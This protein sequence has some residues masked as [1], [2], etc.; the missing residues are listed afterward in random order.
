VP[1]SA[2]RSGAGGALRGRASSCVWAS[3]SGRGVGRITSAPCASARASHASVFATC[4]VARA[5]SRACRGWTITPGRPAV[6]HAVVAPRSR[7]PGASRTIRVGG[8]ACT[9]ST[10]VTTPPASW[11]TAHRAPAGRT[12]LSPWACATSIPTTHGTATRRTPVGPPLQRRALRHQTPGRACGVQDV[13][14]HAP[15][16]SRRTNA[17]SVSHVQGRG[18][19]DSPTSPL[20]IQGCWR[21]PAGQ[22]EV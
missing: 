8:R 20:K 1:R 13:T 7:P 9:R 5:P 18:E 15:L 2:G 6:A 3:G 11:G 16:R 4:P 12:A 10:S 21:S 22:L 19:G 17:A 14:T